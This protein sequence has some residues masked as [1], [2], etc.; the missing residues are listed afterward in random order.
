[1]KEQITT[2]IHTLSMYDYILFGSALFLFVFFLIVAMLLRERFGLAITFILLGF[3]ILMFTPTLGYVKL[4]KYLYKNSL[5][6]LSYKKLHFSDAVVIKGSLSNL[7]KF[8]FK[9]C[10][11]EV[12]AYKNTANKYKNYIYRLKPLKKMSIIQT[13]IKQGETRNFKI[14]MDPF[15]YQKDFNISLG[16][17][18]R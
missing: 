6:L 7:S 11:I 16:A 15:V 17:N 5:Q 14:L 2:F 13:D 4:H 1:M 9:E 3:T 8:H 18:C 10:T 12:I